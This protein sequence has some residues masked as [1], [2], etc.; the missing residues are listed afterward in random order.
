M[1]LFLRLYR[2]G[3]AF[4]DAEISLLVKD[5]LRGSSIKVRP[6]KISKNIP[7]KALGSS[8]VCNVF[9]PILHSPEDVVGSDAGAKYR[10]S[11]RYGFSGCADFDEHPVEKM[12]RPSPLMIENAL[13]RR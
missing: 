10:T 8:R 13:Q 9:S 7:F 12:K 2:S 5:L 3:E 1:T 6:V 11:A 4:V